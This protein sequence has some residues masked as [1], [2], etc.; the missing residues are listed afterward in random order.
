MSKTVF[1]RLDHLPRSNPT[2]VRSVLAAAT[3][4]YFVRADL[5]GAMTDEARG[6]F[7]V[8]AD[9]VIL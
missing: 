1:G 6:V 3:S 8:D 7:E 2:G 4:Y 9:C 5:S